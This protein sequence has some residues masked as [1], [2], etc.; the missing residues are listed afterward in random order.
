MTPECHDILGT[1]FLH[2]EGRGPAWHGLGTSFPD[3]TIDAVDAVQ[4]AG[5]DIKIALFK[6]YIYTQPRPDELANSLTP[7][8]L[9]AVRR[10]IEDYRFVVRQPVAE[11]NEHR[12]LGAVAPSYNIIQ[13][14]DL[15]RAINPLTKS[16][17]VETVGVLA[18]GATLFIVLDAG[19][20][21]IKGDHGKQYFTLLDDK[22]GARALRSLFT[23]V[24][25]VCRNTC[26][27]AERQATTSFS[28]RHTASA[29]LDLRFALQMMKAMEK[30]RTGTLEVFTKMANVTLAESQVDEI[31]RQIYPEPRLSAEKK[32]MLESVD[33][34]AVTTMGFDS[35]DLAQIGDK[36]EKARAWLDNQI[37]RVGAYREGALILYERTNDERPGIA[38][39]AYALYQAAVELA[40]YRDGRGDSRGSALLGERAKEKSRAFEILAGVN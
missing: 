14:I 19:E 12:I 37:K 35:P 16:W 34:G 28:I 30:T 11:D 10:E 24:V 32:L 2:R 8:K 25:T 15:A 22:S 4:R 38:G 21:E 18:N 7:E 36:A 17:P 33:S 27:A 40:D 6:P 13:N 3:G 1:R 20:F 23:P 9:Q 39:T 26:I 31:L 29:Q 5:A